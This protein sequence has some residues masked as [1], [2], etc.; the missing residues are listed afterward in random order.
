MSDPETHKKG[1]QEHKTRLKGIPVSA[2]FGQGYVYYLR[3]GI[4]FDEIY[5]R[6]ASNVHE[7]IDRFEDAVRQSE[8]QVL[9]V[10]HPVETELSRDEQAILQA[11]LMFLR[12]GGLKNKVIDNI[13][14]GHAAEYALKE[15]ILNYVKAF[16]KI[17]DPYIRQRDTDIEN[18]GKRI[19]RNLLGLEDEE[20]SVFKRDTIL[21]ASNLSPA[22][23]IRTRQE[24]LRGIILSKGGETSHVSILARSFEI[25]MVINVRGLSEN[26]KENDFLIVDGTSG[27][28]YPKP[29][30]VVIQEYQRLE[31]EKSRQDKSLD[32]LKV[33]PAQTRDG[34]KVRLGANIGILSDLSLV[35]KYGVDHIGLYRTEFLFLTRDSFPSEDEQANLYRRI[36]EEA[37]GKEVTIRTLDVGGDKFLSYLEYPKEDNPYLGWRSIRV[38]LEL[39]DIFRDQIRAILK[40]SAFGRTKLL[41]PMISSVGEMKEIIAMIS[42]EKANLRAENIPHDDEIKIGILVEVP[43]AAIILDKLLPYV[44]FIS[45]GT[46]DLVQYVLAVDRNNPKVA[47]IYNPLHPAVISVISEAASLCRKSKKP[48]VICGEAAASPRCAYLYVG[49]GINDL[50]MNAAS[51]PVIKNL[52]RKINQKD[53]K[54][55]LK[56]V[57]SMEDADSIGNFLDNILP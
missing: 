52:I 46:N 48:L 27:L 26:I 28:V 56:Q 33:L 1:R 13:R 23:L 7:E 31:K 10:C 38:S 14:E 36:L 18:I 30:K 17:E 43:A 50:S 12:D 57:L 3:E 24:N 39:K 2:G 29:S 6:E 35:E 21:I 19:L 25:P 41:F 54:R 22:E 53:A 47:S 42:E 20:T 40:A 51:V 34:F 15:V 5:F 4:G 9:Q 8:S 55:V 45:V 32:A 49:M 37:G 11:Y 44:D 16:S